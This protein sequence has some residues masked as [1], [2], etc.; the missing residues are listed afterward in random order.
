MRKLWLAG[1][2]VSLGCASAP[3]KPPDLAELDKA[4]ALVLQGCYD[5]LIEARDIYARV[6]VA[7][8]RP[9][10]VSRIFTG[11][12]IPPTFLPPVFDRLRQAD[13]TS[14]R[15]HGGLGIGLAIVRHLVALHGGT[16]R[17]EQGARG[18]RFIVELPGARR[19]PRPVAAVA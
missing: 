9:F 7:R 19:E 4:D 16:A 14:T 5:C 17:L 1:L 11:K 6:G 12:G 2:V 3:L 10:V 8:A 13:S 18:A 15:A